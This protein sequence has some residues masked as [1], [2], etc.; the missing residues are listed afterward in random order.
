M[1]EDIEIVVVGGGVAGLI[2]AAHAARQGARVVLVDPQPLGGRARSVVQHGITLNLGAHALYPG[3]FRRELAALGVSPTG[4]APSADR[5]GVRAGDRIAPFPTD[6]WRLAR[7]PL[8]GARGKVAIAALLGRIGRLDPS[9]FVG[10]TVDEWLSSTP[11]DAGRLVRMFVRVTSYTNAPALL[12]AGAAI[13][14]LQ[15]G[16]RGVTYVDGGWQSIVDSLTHVAASAG[17]ELR[18][19][20]ATSVR[21]E[22]ERVVVSTAAGDLAAAAVVVAGGGPGTAAQLVGRP[23]PG[24]ERLGPPVEAAVLDVATETIASTPVLFGIDRPLYWSVHAPVAHLT[25]ATASLGTAM[26]YLPVGA[27][28]PPHEESRRQL[29]DHAR[30]AGADVDGAIFTRF[31]RAMTVHHGVP[32]AAAG[33]LAGRPTVA[34]YEAE[35]TTR[36]IFIAGDWVGPRGMLAD[37]A[38][39]SA[40]AAARAAVDTVKRGDGVRAAAAAET[41][42]LRR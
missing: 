22:R 17:V 42:G 2:A 41:S 14:Q 15:L 40:V 24:A 12:D 5:G 35:P 13:G 19:D 26:Q 18:H 16:L 7:S 4:G 10:R 34:A 32:T 1:T 21:R 6:A 38:A 9:A 30:V 39:E 37:A 3:A 23:V 20:G 33:G 11:D 29:E 36:G 8:L 31:L 25:L 28:R 27:A